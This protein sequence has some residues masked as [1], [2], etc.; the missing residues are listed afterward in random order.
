MSTEVKLP[1]FGMGM[2]EGTLA[3]WLKKDGDDVKAGELLL[4][5]ETSKSINEVEAPASG[6]LSILVAAGE[7]VPTYT[8]IGHIV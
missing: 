7:T 2:S 5:V 8:V 1:Q 6:R 4:E 3:Q